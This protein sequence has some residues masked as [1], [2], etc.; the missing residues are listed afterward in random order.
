MRSQ[1][2]TPILML[3]ARSTEQDHVHGLDQ[4]ADDYLTKPF[5]PQTLLAH[6]RA[7]LRRY[8]WDR[9]APLAAGD[10][11]LSLEDRTIS[12]CDGEPLH[13]TKREFALLQYLVA[14]PERTISTERLTS[15]VWGYAGPDDRQLLKQVVHRIRLKIE[16]DPAEPRYLLT[17]SGVG[18]LLRPTPREE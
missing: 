9:P 8:D 7:L 2:T 3:T 13:L 17:I 1:A 18:Y 16:R 14:N 15:Q 6:V 4:G 11:R 10:L 5:S 12:I